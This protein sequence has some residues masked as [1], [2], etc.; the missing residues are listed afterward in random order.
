MIS[1]GR[2][3]NEPTMGSKGRARWVLEWEPLGAAGHEPGNLHSTQ[4]MQIYFIKR[5]G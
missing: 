5:R 4:Y 1:K 2:G 3:Y